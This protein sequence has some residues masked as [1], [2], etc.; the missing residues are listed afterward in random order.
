MTLNGCDACGNCDYEYCGELICWRGRELSTMYSNALRD[1]IN[2]YL[3]QDD[4]FRFN[5]GLISD[6]YFLVKKHYCNKDLTKV[7]ACAELC[8]SGLNDKIYFIDWIDS[9]VRK[10]NYVYKLLEELKKRF[11]YDGIFIIPRQIIKI[12]SRYWFQQMDGIFTVYDIFDKFDE[13]EKK[14]NRLVSLYEFE[15]LFENKLFISILSLCNDYC[16]DFYTYEMFKRENGNLDELVRVAKSSHVYK[17]LI[18]KKFNNI[19]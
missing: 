15:D 18:K 4:R 11:D 6:V 10:H 13:I 9:V 8:K 3:F 2:N 16:C 5:L 19:Y 14:E 7:V 1:F 17:K 12:S